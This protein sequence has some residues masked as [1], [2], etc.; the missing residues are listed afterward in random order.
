MCFYCNRVDAVSEQQHNLDSRERFSGKVLGCILAFT[1]VSLLHEFW[2][3]WVVLFCLHISHG[4]WLFHP[5]PLSLY[6]KG[7]VNLDRFFWHHWLLS[8]RQFWHF[9][10]DLS[11]AYRQFFSRGG[12]GGGEPFAQKFSQVAHI[13][14]KQWKRNKGHMMHNISLHMKWKYS[15]ESIAWAHKTC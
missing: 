11:L 3:R 7:F 1:R 8:G 15:Y 9:N 4:A 13:S 6:V 10:F 14:L 12:G 5:L 2:V